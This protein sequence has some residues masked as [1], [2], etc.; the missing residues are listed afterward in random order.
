MNN[1]MNFIPNMNMI[2]DINNINNNMNMNPNM[3]PNMNNNMD[4]LQQ[5]M[6][7]Q[8]MMAQQQMMQQQM[9]QQMMAQQ[10][11]MQQQIMQQN[12]D[13]FNKNSLEE[14]RK[15]KKEEE[16]KKIKNY[17]DSKLY[18]IDYKRIKDQNKS[19]IKMIDILM[20]HI[21]SLEKC[22]EYNEKIML[23]YSKDPNNKIN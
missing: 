11:V 6:M 10:Q 1:N 12:L 3:M 15:R 14:E 8:Q 16:I 9:M 21:Q 5:Q 13:E 20:N 17:F 7:Q 2:G 23:D 18:E 19:F 4:M 22:V